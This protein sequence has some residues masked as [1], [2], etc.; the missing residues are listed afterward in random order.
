MEQTLYGPNGL[1]HRLRFAAHFD[2]GSPAD[3]IDLIM[4][5]DHPDIFIKTAEE[6]NRLL[7]AVYIQ[8]LFKHYPT[9]LPD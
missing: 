5:F 9:T 6:R 3:D 7:H 2:I 8:N 4:L 1:R